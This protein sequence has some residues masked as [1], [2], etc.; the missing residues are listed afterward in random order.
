LPKA[1]SSSLK[2]V[3]IVMETMRREMR[4]PISI[5][6]HQQCPYRRDNQKGRQ[7]RNAHL[8]EKIR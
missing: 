5:I 2:A 1:S 7:R 8:C 6:F 3:P 4:V